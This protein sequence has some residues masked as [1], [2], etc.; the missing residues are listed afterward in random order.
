VVKVLKQDIL[1]G[2]YPLDAQLPTESALQERFGVSRYTVREA[3]RQLKEAGL[4][5]S[6]QGSGR[7]VVRPG[8]PQ[9]YVH[10][11][12]SVSDLM[13]GKATELRILSTGV[14]TADAALTR[15][16]GGKVRQRWLKVEGRRFGKDD[17][18]PLCHTRVFVD[19]EFAGVERH[20]GRRPGPI[21]L[22]VEELYGELVVMIEQTFRATSVSAATAELI[23]VT[24]GETAIEVRR[25][26]RL[27]TGKVA[28]VAVNFYPADRFYHTMTL[29]RS[30]PDGT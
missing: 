16:I 4:I 3:L 5:T 29:R 9:T 10:E 20:L 15:E 22:L 11:V 6:R 28:I 23:D 13:L 26:Y 30:R 21:Y 18:R 14:I 17:S 7:T 25:T 12:A 8:G 2:V 19:G 27:A 24:P 1:S